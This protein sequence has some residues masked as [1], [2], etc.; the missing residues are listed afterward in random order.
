MAA[1]VVLTVG[2]TVSALP[3]A[4][5]DASQLSRKEKATATGK[6]QPHEDLTPAEREV[7]DVT[8][9]PRDWEALGKKKATRAGNTLPAPRS[10]P[11][12][13]ISPEAGARQDEEAGLQ[14]P[15]HIAQPSDYDEDAAEEWP[16]SDEDDEG[17]RAPSGGL[18]KSPVQSLSKQCLAESQAKTK[19]GNIFHRFL[20]CRDSKV[21]FRYFTP[22]PYGKF[23]RGKV[24]A[25]QRTVSQASKGK[26]GIRFHRAY[27]QFVAGSISYSFRLPID[28]VRAEYIKLGSRSTCQQGPRVCDV[29][30]SGFQGQ[31]IKDWKRERPWRSQWFY[32][33]I[34][35]KPGTSKGRDQL[36]YHKWRVE[37][38]TWG[39]LF[40]IVPLRRHVSEYRQLRCHTVYNKYGS[41]EAQDGCAF[42]EK[43]LMMP[44]S[45]S[46]SETKE[47]VEHIEQ[48]V[49][50]PDTTYPLSAPPGTDNP[51]R[52]E[53]PGVWG[54]GPRAPLHR[55]QIMDPR[56][57]ANESHKDQACE[58]RGRYA[59]TGIPP[60][61][62]PGSGQDCDE[63]PFQSTLEGASNREWDFSVKA[64]KSDHNQK[65]GGALGKFFTKN[66][67]LPWDDNLLAPANERFWVHFVR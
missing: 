10:A 9:A 6:D 47:A 3:S 28:Q 54:V 62:Q 53:I 19:H 49:T 50:M 40:P 18:G 42:S 32:Q 46:N 60:A 48:A 16:D 4:A 52:K 31:E 67:V 65:A 38:T 61:K 14:H 39:T 24:D 17:A 55:L 7:I 22:T 12:S 43:P 13:D 36:V 59:K 56:R 20:F 37:W 34:T 8:M 63:Y 64:I 1:S 41:S 5:A 66:V 51:P 30:G 11:G 35:N 45:L 29:S 26:N 58:Q 44:Y 33:D 15:G 2:L 57:A 27:T 21:R 23:Y 25:T